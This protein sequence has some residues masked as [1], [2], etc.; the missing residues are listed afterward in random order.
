MGVRVGVGGRWG[1]VMGFGGF[2]VSSV[3]GVVYQ[4]SRGGYRKHP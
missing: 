3:V 2:E 4:C 1:V